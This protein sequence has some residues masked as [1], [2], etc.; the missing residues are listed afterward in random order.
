MGT[1]FIFVLMGLAIVYVAFTLWRIRRL[2]DENLKL[3]NE[4]RE[5]EDRVNLLKF[6][7]L[8]YKMK[9]PKTGDAV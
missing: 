8:S 7:C 6:V 9:Q 5:K 2:S 3:K 4:L 1:E